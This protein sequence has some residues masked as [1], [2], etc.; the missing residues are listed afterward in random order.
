MITLN[1]IL[2]KI[3]R[4]GLALIALFLSSP[5]VFSQDCLDFSDM[6]ETA[7]H[8]NDDALFPIGSVYTAAG[9]LKLKKSHSGDWD[10]TW[11]QSTINSY[12][13]T[14][15]FFHGYM[16][17]DVSASPY[18]CKELTIDGFAQNVVI[19]GDTIDVTGGAFAPYSGSGFELDTTSTGYIVTGVFLAVSAS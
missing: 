16:T 17:F 14:Q 4:T 3:K 12:T 10:A 11:Q 19:D 9:D 2:G 15:I 7:A 1:R 8:Y 6:T 5:L 18:W 13:A